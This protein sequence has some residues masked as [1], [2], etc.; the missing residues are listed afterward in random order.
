MAA[1][2]RVLDQ[3]VV[4]PQG[5]LEGAG[6]LLASGRLSPEA[7]AVAARA[8]G[9]AE[10][11]LGRLAE[12]RGRLASG[13]DA[14]L[15]SGLVNKAAEIQLVLAVV[16]L[17]DEEPAEALE[18]ID[19]AIERAGDSAT[20]GKAQSQRATILMR[21]G[22]ID[23]AFDQS[24]LALRTCRAGG[25]IQSV[26]QI[27]SNRGVAFTYRGQFTRA[28]AELE[29]A[30]AL[31]KQ[32]GSDRTAAQV[33][34]N[35]GY[36]AGRRGDVPR[37]LSRFDESLAEFARLGVPADVSPVDRCEVLMSAWLLPEAQEAAQDAVARLTAAG[38]LADL[39]EARLSLAE[40]E[41]ALG[42]FA[43]ALDQAEAAEAAFVRQDRPGWAALARFAVGR[44]R[45][46]AGPC[47]S[48]KTVLAEGIELVVAL[49][50]AGWTSQALECRISAARAALQLG[51]H[52]LA[53]TIA[54]GAASPARAASW[55]ERARAAY[56]VGLSE[57]AA[58]DRSSALAC[59]RKSVEISEE[60]A[61]LFAATELRAMSAATSG[62][63]ADLGLRLALEGGDTEEIFTWA[64]IRRARSLWRPTARP[65]A[66]PDLA[67][68]L[69]AL[70]HTASSLARSNAAGQD[71]EVL[72]SE[73][74]R[75]EAAVRAH[76][77]RRLP[78]GPADL[79]PGPAILSV[80]PGDLS[81][82]RR[83]SEERR[84]ELPNLSANLSGFMESLGAR[85]LVEMIEAGGN[86]SAL[87]I[88]RSRADLVE[89]GPLGDVGRS[90]AGMRFGL[91]RLVE[92]RGGAATM[93][94]AA[95]LLLRSTAALDE[96]LMQPIA[97]LLGDKGQTRSVTGGPP[98]TVVL[99]PTGSLHSISWALLPTLA[100][101]AFCVA[102]S[103][104]VWQDCAARAGHEGADRVVLVAGPGLV[105]APGEVSAIAGCYR[106]AL[107]LAGKDATVARVTSAASG[108]AVLHVAAHG[109]F[110]ADNPLFSSL[111]LHDGELTVYDL[112]LLRVP[113][114]LVVA[115]A[116]DAGRA[117]VR[118]GDQLMGT[119]A[120]MLS[121][122]TQTVV[123]SNSPVGDAC[124]PELMTLLHA[125]VSSGG[126]VP[127]ALASLRGLYPAVTPATACLA[128]RAPSALAALAAGS[129]VCLGSDAAPLGRQQGAMRRSQL[130]VSITK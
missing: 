105:T 63:P 12:A 45:W 16:L 6:K 102:P 64:E 76:S 71:V 95:E 75:L 30:H 41:L 42:D 55:H 78:P 3:A 15:E 54:A 1:A 74:R 66:D 127:A 56:A 59:L 57:L 101:R 32:L 121:I 72:R 46:A 23:E 21:L 51:D 110:R 50:Q 83:P 17:Q 13:R 36:L 117:D 82:S 113:P 96:A 97:R 109:R 116:C 68:L 28:E 124:L 37:A 52:A 119:S 107:V 129:F 18:Q 10:L 93:Q 39:P 60:Q 43:S 26:A 73:R 8:A 40:V 2:E 49:E 115:S 92:G 69:T 38:L 84:P 34:H 22:R 67:E 123:A 53:S 79:P 122:G 70:R 106:D 91:S 90:A 58:G 29:E 114:R 62:D 118:P 47:P 44:A 9:V 24:D 112:E 108:A 31:L 48:P 126:T 14:A 100:D 111:A 120:A 61:G 80:G 98:T 77:L 65:P 27:L 86:L 33:L 94:A 125:A 104:A 20:L 128:S 25:L 89:L 5:A 103:A 19:M 7:A 85:T 35:L 81:P 4:D 130:T 87:V 11:H 99:V 88:T